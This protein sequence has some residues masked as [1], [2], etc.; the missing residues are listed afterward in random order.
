M[1]LACVKSKALHVH[2]CGYDFIFYEK[3]TWK[4]IAATN[5]NGH[6]HRCGDPDVAISFDHEKYKLQFSSY[7]FSALLIV[8]SIS[9]FAAAPVQRRPLSSDCAP[10]SISSES[11]I[12]RRTHDWYRK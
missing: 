5:N 10:F 8:I 11:T 1:R 2:M 4:M 6:W 12:Y 7:N 9:P 3:K